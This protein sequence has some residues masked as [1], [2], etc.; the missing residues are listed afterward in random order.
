MIRLFL[1][2]LERQKQLLLKKDAQMLSYLKQDMF[3]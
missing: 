3:P 2:D 1:E